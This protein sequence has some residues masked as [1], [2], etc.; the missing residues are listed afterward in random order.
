MQPVTQQQATTSYNDVQSALQQQQAFAQAVQPG[1]LAGLQSQQ[2]LLGQLQD[3]SQ[4][5]GPNP[6]LAQL[7]QTTGQNVANQA[8]LMAGQRGSGANAGLIARQAAQ[9]GAATQQNA[10]G[11][12]AILKAQQQLA[13][14]GQLQQQQQAMI[15]QQ[16]GAT[17]AASTSQQNEQQNLLNSISG[18]NN[19]NVSQQSN[20]NNSNTSMA[21]VSMQGQQNLLGNVMGGAGS[22]L[23]LADGGEVNSAEYDVSPSGE[24]VSTA[25]PASSG[26][27][28]IPKIGN[29]FQSKSGGGGSGLLSLA[30]LAAKGGKVSDIPKMALGGAPVGITPLQTLASPGQASGPQSSVGQYFT[31][32]KTGSGVQPGTISSGGGPNITS[33]TNAWAKN[34]SSSPSKATNMSDDDTQE[35]YLDAD[36][37]LGVAGADNKEVE[38]PASNANFD[39]AAAKGGKVPALVSPGE[40]YLNPAKVDKV[41]QGASPMKEGALVPGKPKVGGAKNSYANDTVPADL[42]PGGIVIP[43]SVTQ[44]KDAEKKAIAFVRSVLAKKGGLPK[45]S[46]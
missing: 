45:K 36:A 38:M 22:A 28:N 19:A 3:Q 32:A 26:S 5:K 41:K 11:Q 21:G 33:I 43:R 23:G 18:V 10:V 37:A 7:N 24:G 40:R 31:E 13:A 8:A 42:D 25:G 9:Q 34:P 27:S 44:A 16:A 20:I 6:A 30:A 4:G 15:G 1:G 46:K 2:Q 17:N 35:A 29:A 12:A 39:F 14:Q